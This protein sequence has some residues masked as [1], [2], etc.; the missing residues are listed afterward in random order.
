[1]ESVV[2]I[3]SPLGSLTWGMRAHV[4]L[5]ISFSLN[6]LVFHDRPARRNSACRPDGRRS[7]KHHQNDLGVPRTRRP[8]SG[9]AYPDC[10]RPTLARDQLVEHVVNRPLARYGPDLVIFHGGSPGVD[11]SF[12]V[13]CR[14]LG[15]IAEPYVADWRGLANIAGPAQP[16]GGPGADLCIALHQALAINKVK[17]D[18]IRQVLAAGTKER[19]EQSTMMHDLHSHKSV[20]KD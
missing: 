9:H 17:K 11:Q 16:G 7:P 6:V 20:R 15:V 19:T 2:S 10:R 1:M 4:G 14:E 13:A 3:E 12:A 8:L 18:C 5:P